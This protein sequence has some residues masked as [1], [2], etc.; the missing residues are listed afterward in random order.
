MFTGAFNVLYAGRL[1]KEKGIDM[2][3]DAFLAAQREDPR[4][5]LVLAGGGPEEDA[6]RDRLGDR[7]TFLG[8]L[9]DEALA[10]AYASADAFLFA[11]ATDTFGQVILEAQA[12]GLPVVA[13]AAGGPA[14]LIE[15]G[16]S[17]IL[18]PADSGALAGALHRL[19]RDVRLQEHLRRGG[20]GA[21]RGRTWEAALARLG[22]GYRAALGSAHSDAGRRAA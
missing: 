8:W 11:S 4:L 1:T 19:A 13:V 18:C 16:C 5:H 20:L 12:S 15:D 22:D 10:Q 6:L 21:V 17:G 3:A 9:R 14:T 7:A 2:L